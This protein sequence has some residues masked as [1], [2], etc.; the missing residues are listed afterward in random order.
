LVAAVAE[1][2]AR[3]AVVQRGIG[4]WPQLNHFIPVCQPAQ[5]QRMPL[6]VTLQATGGEATTFDVVGTSSWV[7]DGEGPEQ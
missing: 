7:E 3:K 2:G 6:R 1:L 4:V 5:W